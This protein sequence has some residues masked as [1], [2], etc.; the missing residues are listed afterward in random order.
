MVSDLGQVEKRLERVE[1]DL[2]K[3]RTGELEREHALLL[4][5][6]SR[7]KRRFRCANWR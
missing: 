4:G 1:K 5:Q 6:K 7:W 2:K 3:Q